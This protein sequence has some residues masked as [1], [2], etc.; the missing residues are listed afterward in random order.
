MRY[1]IYLAFALSMVSNFFLIDENTKYKVLIE[2]LG[3][4]FRQFTQAKIGD[5]TIEQSMVPGRYG[6]YQSSGKMIACAIL[7]PN[8]NPET[9]KWTP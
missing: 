7:K 6:I 9:N 5:K 2:S 1:Y 4:G 8:Y 3:N